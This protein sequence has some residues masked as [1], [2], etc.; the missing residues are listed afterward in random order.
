MFRIV[1]LL[2]IVTKK[3]M[4]TKD[5]VKLTRLNGSQLAKQR[6]RNLF[7]SEK[8]RSLMLKD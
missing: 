7:F 1:T 2:P 5:T 8:T 3:R 6:E 4:D